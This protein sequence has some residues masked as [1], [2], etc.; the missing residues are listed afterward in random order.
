MVKHIETV[1]DIVLNLSYWDCEC[2]DNFIHTLKENKCTACGATQEESPN[3]R[4]REV[5]TLLRRRDV[6]K[7][8]RNK[9]TYK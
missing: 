9:S 2:G 1:G 6:P 7:I 5:E 4:E 3:S 8:V